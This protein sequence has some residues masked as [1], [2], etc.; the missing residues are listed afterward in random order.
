MLSAFLFVLNLYLQKGVAH[1]NAPFVPQ[2]ERVML[3]ENT[4]Y[5]T[6]FLQTGLGKSVVDKLKNA[7][8]FDK[9]LEAQEIFFAE[10]KI[11]CNKMLG[12][13]T[14]EDRL[15]EGDSTPFYDL[16]LGDILIT[17]STH[18]LG[19]RHGH[20]ALITGKNML[21]ECESIGTYSA[22]SG[23][24]YWGSYSNYA[25]LRPKGVTKELQQEVTDYSLSELVGLPYRLT[26]G[27]LGP[28]E[29]DLKSKNAGFYCTN[30][31]WYAWNHFGI[32]L[33]SDGGKFVTSFDLV[34]S[35]KLEVVQLYGINP[36]DFLDRIG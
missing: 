28:K 2:Y 12:H 6:L 13:F 8:Q 18:S 20:A 5:E 34:N 24:Y 33:D 22:E 31:I 26:S 32:D 14:M 10:P 16:Q 21:L 19:W 36:E 27:M 1:R 4:D 7:G 15:E 29:I 25:V 35:D 17:F 3:T 11:E 30:L 9:I 23:I